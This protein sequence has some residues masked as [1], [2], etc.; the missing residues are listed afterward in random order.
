MSRHRSRFGPVMSESVAKAR[1]SPGSRRRIVDI[2]RFF[3]RPVP[4]R[5][6]FA[7]DL[8]MEREGRW[9]DVSGHG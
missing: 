3:S 2:P 1:I 4:A 6:A 8:D 9:C 7:T 5:D